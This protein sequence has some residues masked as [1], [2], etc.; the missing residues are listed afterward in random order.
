MEENELQAHRFQKKNKN[1]LASENETEQKKKEKIEKRR[2]KSQRQRQILS[3]LE[4]SCL[5]QLGI[6]SPRE[7]KR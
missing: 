3:V 1:K 7:I 4:A 5:L 2:E 6:G